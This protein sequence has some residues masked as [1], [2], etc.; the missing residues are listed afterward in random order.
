MKNFISLIIL[1]FMVSLSFGQSLTFSGTVT[2]TTNTPIEY[3]AIGILNKPVGT[4]SNSNG[5]FSLSLDSSNLTDTLKISSLGYESE[6]LLISKIEGKKHLNIILIPFAEPLNEISISSKKMKTYTEGKSKTNTKQQVIFANPDMPNI[7]LG[8]EIGRKFKLEDNDPS[9]LE[10]FRFFIKDNNFDSTKFRIN[11][12]LISENNRP[13]RKLNTPKIFASASKN[14][15][16]W[17][18]VDLSPF[19]IIVK[20]DIIVAV[21][22]IEHSDKGDLLNLPIIIPSFGSTHYYKFG[23]QNSWKKYGGISSSMELTYIK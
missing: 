9:K 12:Y 21:E 19:D 23:S 17:V 10:K 16:G 18:E 15:T 13:D 8:T 6:E 20:E 11:I 5:N 1:Q 4:V 3:A 2:D 14:Y 7:N 22:W